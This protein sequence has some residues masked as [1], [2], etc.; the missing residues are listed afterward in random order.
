MRDPAFQLDIS[1]V[2]GHSDERGNERADGKVKVA[3]KGRSSHVHS[4]PDFLSD[5]QI[6]MSISTWWQK[7]DSYLKSTWRVV[8]AA[9]P[10]HNRI[11]RINPSLPSKASC[12]LTK[13]INHNQ[14]SILT[15]FRSGHVPLNKYLHR[16]NKASSLGCCY[17]SFHARS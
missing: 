16:I 5:G 7:S 8:W 1:W 4:P 6:P 17:D 10:R 15:Q 12:K 2:K 9:S 13:G 11:H 3:A 14:T